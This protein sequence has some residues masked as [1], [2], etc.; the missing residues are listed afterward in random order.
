MIKKQ[1]DILSKKGHFYFKAD[2]TVII[3]KAYLGRY[4]MKELISTGVKSKKVIIASVLGLAIII[5]IFV[6]IFNAANVFAYSRCW[7]VQIGDKEQV[8]IFSSEEKATAVIEGVKNSYLTK[9]SKVLAIECDPEMSVVE[10]TAKKDDNAIDIMSVDDAI[11]FITLGTKEPKIYTIKNGDTLWEIAKENSFTVDELENMNKGIDAEL[12]HNGDEIKLYEIKPFLKVK[13]TEVIT[14]NESIKYKTKYEKTSKLLKGQ[15][16]V[17]A[18]GKKGSK[19]V[20]AEYIK[21]NGKTINMDVKSEN[22]INKPVTKVVLKGTKVIYSITRGKTYSGSGTAVAGYALQFVGNPYSYGGTSLTNGA[23][24]SGFVLAVYKHFGIPLVHDANA[25]RNYG[26]MVSLNSARPGDIV[27]YAGHV[28]IYV[29][30]GRI[31]HA[32]NSSAGIVVSSVNVM[33][34]NQVRRILN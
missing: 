18:E 19:V 8:V 16:Q 31:V 26:V 5:T 2:N 10:I 21:E 30:S 15:S 14:S 33:S 9:D 32:Y 24:C 28:G 4:I 1:P 17:K 25:I 23:D 34:V 3:N 13:T 11:K 12:I 27:C 22:I 7:A 29:G 6:G 20:T